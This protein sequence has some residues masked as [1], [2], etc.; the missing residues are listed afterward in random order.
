M[1]YKTMREETYRD[2]YIVDRLLEYDYGNASS[3]DCRCALPVWSKTH[4]I[5][6]LI[7][8]YKIQSPGERLSC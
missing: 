2:I 5:L 3:V 4:L 6:Q 7:P 1:P 8:V